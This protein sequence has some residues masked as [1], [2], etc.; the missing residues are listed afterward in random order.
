MAKGFFDRMNP[1]IESEL[2]SPAQAQLKL[3]ATREGDLIKANVTVDPIKGASPD[4][5]VQLAL[6]EDE[7]RYTG[8]NG[9]R[10]HP[11]VVRSLGGKDAS[12]FGLTTGGPTN[13]EWTFDLKTM[14]DELKKYLDAYEHEGHR[15]EAF[16]FSEKKF[17][18]DSNNL[19]L[20]AFVQ[21]MK[22]KNVLQTVYMKLGPTMTSPAQTAAK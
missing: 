4:L 21:D 8:E 18:I 17:Q 1:K 10:F 11:M 9:V 2:E 22:T 19:S 6:T 20:V 7:L 16:T 15:G 3:T 14:S 13:I 12:G 5:K